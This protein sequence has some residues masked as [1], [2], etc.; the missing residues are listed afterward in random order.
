VNVAEVQSLDVAEGSDEGIVSTVLVV[1][2]K[3][4]SS[5][6]ITSV[7]GLTLTGTKAAGVS[8]ALQIT[9]SSKSCEKGNSL[10]GLGDGINIDISNDQ[11]NLSDLL[12]TVTTSHYEGG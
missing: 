10:L 2:E 6:D 8:N 4:S 3:R 11:R 1:D 5:L 12:N 7:P 9:S